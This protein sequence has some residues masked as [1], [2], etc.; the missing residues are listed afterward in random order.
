MSL[1][2]DA[3]VEV[4]DGRE[5]DRAVAIGARLI[6]INNRDLT[7]LKVD[8]RTT[9]ELRERVPAQALVVAESG[10]SSRDQLEALERAEVDAVLIGEALMRSP[11]IELACRA[12]TRL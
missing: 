5:L 9:F 4:H 2:L 7:T 10:F 8:T 6:G 3:L 1:G 11:D 12:L